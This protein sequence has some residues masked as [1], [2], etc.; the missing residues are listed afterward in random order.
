MCQG[1]VQGS[2]VELTRVA[3]GFQLENK[4]ERRIKDQHKD[5]SLSNWKNKVAEIGKYWGG[6]GRGCQQFG[7]EHI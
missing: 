6:R 3:D 7:F 4:R 1:D 2:Q 5:F